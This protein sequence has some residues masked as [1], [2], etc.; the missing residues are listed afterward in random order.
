VYTLHPR[1]AA[2]MTDTAAVMPVII[3]LLRAVNA[4][5]DG[6]DNDAFQAG[7]GSRHAHANGCFCHRLHFT[8]I[9]LAAPLCQ[10]P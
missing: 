3:E 8:V 1:L 10:L 7:S 6:D 2:A 5:E 4:D 9:G